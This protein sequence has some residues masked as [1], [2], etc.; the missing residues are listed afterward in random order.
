MESFGDFGSKIQTLV[1]HLLYLQMTDPGAKSIV[2]SAWADSLHSMFIVIFDLIVHVADEP[3][4]FERALLVNGKC[5]YITTMQQSKHSLGI[6]CLRIDQKSK[7]EGAA[8]R[9]KKDPNI[10]VLLLH[11]FVG[12]LRHQEYS[13]DLISQQ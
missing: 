4:V 6:R 8:K 9:F 11:G 2:F 10:L 7:G 3:K 12:V 5:L 13:I 1:C